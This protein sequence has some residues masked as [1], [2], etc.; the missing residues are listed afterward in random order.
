VAFR[1]AG[2]CR[3]AGAVAAAAVSVLAGSACASAAVVVDGH[4]GAAPVV[5]AVDA[6][7]DVDGAVPTLAALVRAYHADR[8]GFRAAVV[9]QLTA[10][11]VPVVEGGRGLRAGHPRPGLVLVVRLQD[12]VDCAEDDVDAGVVAGEPPRVLGCGA[13][14]LAGLALF[15]TAVVA[16]PAA[17]VALLVAEDDDD[18][19]ALLPATAKHAWVAE[20][21]FASGVDVD[22]LDIVAAEPAW[23]SLA[24]TGADV[25][26][27]FVAAGRVVAWSPP[28]R[29]PVVVAERLARLPPDGPLGLWRRDAVA[30]AR[31]PAL[32]ALVVD[33]CGLADF[34]AGRA[35]SDVAARARVRCRVLPGGDGGAFVDELHRVVADDAVAVAVEDS[36]AAS[37]TTLSAPVPA[38]LARRVASFSPRAVAAPALSVLPRPSACGLLRA[39]GLSCVGAV[40]VLAHPLRR[41]RRGRPAQPAGDA[42]DVAAVQRGAA[43]AVAVVADVTALFDRL[44]P[45]DAGARRPH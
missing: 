7:V 16:L 22:V 37:S 9:E 36:V 24:L 30:L 17:P 5:A 11:G 6:V 12:V 23:W 40:P 44:S 43:I 29:L 2:A 33:D 35:V 4:D 18:I 39:R 21:G 14:D 8:R 13:Q 19:E 38:A 20:G 3:L 15:V 1:V 42:V 26:R 28:P 45:P 41:A 27:V 31:E 25:D 32:R 34:D 10:A